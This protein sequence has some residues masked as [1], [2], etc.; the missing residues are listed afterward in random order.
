MLASAPIPNSDVI[1]PGGAWV[2]AFFRLL[3]ISN[4][5]PGFRTIH[6]SRHRELGARFPSVPSPVIFA[7]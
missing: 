6:Y 2:S 5:Y 4:V 3:G 7:N 1:G